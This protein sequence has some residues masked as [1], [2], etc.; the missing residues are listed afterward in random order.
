MRRALFALLAL[1]AACH[2]ASPAPARPSE[3]AAGTAPVARSAPSSPSSPTNELSEETLAAARLA[4]V[5]APRVSLLW[6]RPTSYI[7]VAAGQPPSPEYPAGTVFVAAALDLDRRGKPRLI[8]WDVARGAPLREGYPLLHDDQKVDIGS[9]REARITSTGDSVFTVVTLERSTQSQVRGWHRDSLGAKGISWF[10]AAES[11]ALE[12]DAEWVVVG[13]AQNGPRYEHYPEAGLA[14]F[15]ASTL[16]RVATAAT[17][18]PARQRDVRHDY[19]EI[20]DGRLFAAEEA[21]APGGLRVT[22]HALPSLRVLRSVVVPV[23]PAERYLG[24]VQLTSSR[25]HLFVVGR[26]AIAELTPELTVV[27]R[28]DFQAGEVAIGPSGE[29]LTP[30]GLERPGIRRDFVP[31]LGTAA[32]CTPAWSASHPLLACAV[33]M[34]GSRI[35]RLGAR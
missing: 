11:I 13:Y 30:L 15:S 28:R 18:A 25:G 32:S 35:A 26:G 10:S 9:P 20:L 23:R 12:A 3:C 31:A 22:E 7:D 14:V 21:Y 27:G 19:L 2:S 17:R 1:V 16:E 6:R 24:P 29:L 33:D 34:E 4:D 8:E 5:A